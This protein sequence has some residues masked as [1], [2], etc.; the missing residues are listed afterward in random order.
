MEINYWHIYFLTK[1]GQVHVF[2]SEF[3][4]ITF[5]LLELKVLNAIAS[6]KAYGNTKTF[7]QTEMLHTQ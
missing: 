2:V 1:Q 7:I 3:I 5:K 4:K 6:Y